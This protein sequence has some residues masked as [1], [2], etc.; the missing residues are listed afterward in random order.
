M[1]PAYYVQLEAIN[2]LADVARTELAF[3]AW[4]AQVS[5]RPR[6]P[7]CLADDLAIYGEMI[8]D[9][10]YAAGKEPIGWFD[11]HLVEQ[12]EEQIVEEPPAK[13]PKVA[14]PKVANPKVE[15]QKAENPKVG[16]VDPD[17]PGLPLSA[18]AAAAAGN[19][20]NDSV[21]DAATF[22][23]APGRLLGGW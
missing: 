14:K 22:V 3:D 1:D 4:D 21:Y 2:S 11:R 19:D 5:R 16:V 6:A 15:E 17:V 23:E 13:K 10:A 12:A 20:S 18:A 8:P 7:S 9:E